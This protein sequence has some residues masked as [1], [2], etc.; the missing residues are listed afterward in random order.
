MSNIEILYQ[1]LST[2]KREFFPKEFVKFLGF[3][4]YN[5]RKRKGTNEYDLAQAHYTHA[6]NIPEAIHSSIPLALKANFSEEILKA[7]IGDTS[8]MHTHNTLPAMAQ[9][10]RQPMWLVPD[11]PYL[12]EE[13]T[14]TIAGNREIYKKTKDAYEIFTQDLLKRLGNP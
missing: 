11:C 4:I 5:A 12:E 10:Y 6:K 13:D 9:K 8:V 7:P 3:T 14:A 2:D 1:L